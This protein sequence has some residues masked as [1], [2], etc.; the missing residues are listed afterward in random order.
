MQYECS[1]V[2]A[3]LQP[4]TSVS[5]SLSGGCSVWRSGVI[6]LNSAD[7]LSVVIESKH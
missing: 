2:L 6:A 1:V 3:G 4:G 7:S 5:L